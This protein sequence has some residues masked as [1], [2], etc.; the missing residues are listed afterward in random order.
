MTHTSSF[1]SDDLNLVNPN[2]PTTI[3]RRSSTR[4]PRNG[5]IPVIRTIQMFRV[6][7]P[8]P[9][10]DAVTSAGNF[11][12][13]DVVLFFEGLDG[14]LGHVCHDFGVA[15]ARDRHFDG[16]TV[17]CEEVKMTL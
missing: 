8:L 13:D 5:V 17:G 12:P 10:A 6:P 15:V 1:T 4:S 9:G 7:V 11:S 3:C 14:H 16:L 2:C